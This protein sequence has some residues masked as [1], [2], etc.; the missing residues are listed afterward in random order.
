MDLFRMLVQQAPR[1]VLNSV[2]GSRRLAN[3]PLFS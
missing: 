3:S 2:Y 1:A